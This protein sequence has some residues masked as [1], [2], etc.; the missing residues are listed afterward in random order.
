VARRVAILAAAAAALAATVVGLCTVSLVLT[1]NPAR[2]ELVLVA[3]LAGAATVLIVTVATVAI[4]D[5]LLASALR[6]LTSDVRA[7]EAGRYL[8]RS[9]STRTDEIGELSRA[10]DRVCA[11][12]TDLS[13][14][15]IDSDRELAWSRRELKLKEALALLFELTRTMDAESDFETLIRSIPRKI[16]PALGY[17][18]MAILTL[19]EKSGTLVVRATYGFPEAD[20]V[21]GMTFQVGEGISGTVA[22]TGV[23]LII[24]DTT[25]DPR[26]THYKGKHRTTGSFI[27]VPMKVHGRLVG[28][29]NVL[30]PETGGFSEEDVRLLAALASYTALSI[31]H[32]EMNLQLRE[33]SVTD[34]LTGVANR[35]LLLDRL[36]RDVERAR[37]NQKPL[38]VLMVDLDHFKRVNDQHGHL[39]GDEVLSAVAS[40]LGE[41]LRRLDTVARY[42]G[43]EFVVLL[44]DSPKAQ[45]LLIAEKLRLGIKERLPGGVSITL[46]IGVASHPEDADREELLLD[47]ADRALFVAKRQGRDRVVGFASQMADTAAS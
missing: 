4:V 26:Y 14:A 29:F 47:A 2:R 36:G 8:P 27:A 41:G 31:A 10:F 46:S 13:V 24:P 28:M 38:S 16:A 43:E 37:R 40:A 22:V 23:P 45:A 34:E 15:V 35:R 9:R 12:I 11:Q 5:R 30:G 21:E 39:K 19:D 44:P 32:A 20:A 17:D 18:E 3:T 7:A 42:G 25:K 33:L 1:E 6:N